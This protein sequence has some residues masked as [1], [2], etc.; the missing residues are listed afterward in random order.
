MGSR[1]ELGGDRLDELGRGLQRAF[2]LRPG[3]SQGADG[4]N[5][6]S[7]TNRLEHLSLPIAWRERVCR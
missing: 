3:N 7:E 2:R 4:A 5:R 1:Q 6:E